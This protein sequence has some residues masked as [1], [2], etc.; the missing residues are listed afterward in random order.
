RLTA[1]I[2]Q[3]GAVGQ[4]GQTV[5]QGQLF[6]MFLVFP[7][8]GNIGEYANMMRDPSRRITNFGERQ[9]HGEITAVLAPAPQFTLPATEGAQA[10][11]YLPEHG[12]VVAAAGPVQQLI[13]LMAAHL[14]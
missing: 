12:F 10:P 11:E 9:Q 1:P 14:V 4:S 6:E 8:P 3:Q 7:L 2:S 13:E 5:M